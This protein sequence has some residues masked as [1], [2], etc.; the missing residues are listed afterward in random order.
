M[1]RS[2]MFAALAA[3]TLTGCQ[4]IGR[5]YLCQRWGGGPIYSADDQGLPARPRT[6]SA[7]DA[8]GFVEYVDYDVRDWKCW[9]KK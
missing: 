5:Q 9:R 6:I 8:N 1:Y 3:L 2:Y 4:K 7:K